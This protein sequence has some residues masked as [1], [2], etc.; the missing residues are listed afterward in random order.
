MRKVKKSMMKWKKHGKTCVKKVLGGTMAAMLAVSGVNFPDAT[1]AQ[2]ASTKPDQD[3]MKIRFDEPLSKGK[4]TGSSGNFTKPGSDTTGGSSYL[5]QS[6]TL[7]WE[8]TY[9]V[10]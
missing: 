10:K 5:F 7:I 9:M 2:A 4:L 6:E 8:R 1:V 3:P